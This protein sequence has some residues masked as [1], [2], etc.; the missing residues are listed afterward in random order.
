MTTITPLSSCSVPYELNT[1]EQPKEKQ[2]HEA[3]PESV[4]DTVAF[5]ILRDEVE[6]FINELK[7]RQNKSRRDADV[8]QEE[9]ARLRFKVNARLKSVQGIAPQAGDDLGHQEVKAAQA[10]LM[11]LKEAES[12]LRESERGA[13]NLRA[14][15]LPTVV[16]PALLSV[17]AT[18]LQ[19]EPRSAP[20]QSPDPTSLKTPVQTRNA[21][22]AS[23]REGTS[24]T[25]ASVDDI[26]TIG[27]ENMTPEEKFWHLISLWL[28][29]LKEIEKEIDEIYKLT[30]SMSDQMPDEMRLTP[31]IWSEKE[32]VLEKLKEIRDTL[33]TLGD[34]ELQL[35]DG[36]DL[37]DAEVLLQKAG[38]PYKKENGKL[39][40]VIERK[41]DILMKWAI[42]NLEMDRYG[43]LNGNMFDLNER[44]TNIGRNINNY[45]PTT[46]TPDDKHENSFT[47]WVDGVAPPFES[48]AKIN[49]NLYK[50]LIALT[51]AWQKKRN[52]FEEKFAEVLKQSNGPNETTQKHTFKMALV[53]DM[54]DVLKEIDVLKENAALI[55]GNVS[56]ESINK[57]LEGTGIKL[58]DKVGTVAS[59]DMGDELTEM[60][61][62]ALDACFNPDKNDGKDE[63][64]VTA[65]QLAQFQRT[66]E[67]AKLQ[68]D[69][70]TQKLGTKSDQTYSVFKSTQESLSSLLSQ[71]IK[72][73]SDLLAGIR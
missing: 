41:V 24:K 44:L 57:L 38:V 16:K 34:E 32:R 30:S 21:P 25:Y 1:N 37:N 68:F 71:M 59:V 54:M 43:R 64:E 2:Q 40:P 17:T 70:N 23:S 15:A 6:S 60:L 33:K 46:D 45:Y 51:Q 49:M 36:L 18:L 12:V 5:N 22:D 65:E 66:L 27:Q 31:G 61:N 56:I 14:S 13:I 11:R 28:V 4:A 52:E 55:L 53:K 39:K 48:I 10:L 29:R 58:K 72:L 62:D 73:I 8:Q 47:D 67:Q 3:K 69:A 42:A 19:V 26:T 50:S 9:M 63:C 20:V 35:P 7:T